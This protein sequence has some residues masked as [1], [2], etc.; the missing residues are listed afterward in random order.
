M[1][2]ESQKCV[3]HT[4]GGGEQSETT[5][6]RDGAIPIVPSTSVSAFP[7]TTGPKEWGCESHRQTRSLSVG[8]QYGLKWT[9]GG[10]SETGQCQHNVRAVVESH[11]VGDGGS[12]VGATQV[13]SK[14]HARH[15]EAVA[16]FRAGDQTKHACDQRSDA[17]EGGTLATSSS[18]AEMRGARHVTRPDACG[19]PT[20]LGG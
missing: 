9:S 5:G 14:R 19:E 13:V 17:R 8:M 12:E 3:D 11:E 15:A 4:D 16:A 2:N 20:L 1:R 7:S 18:F 10:E 6:G